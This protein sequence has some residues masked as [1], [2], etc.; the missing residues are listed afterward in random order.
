MAMIVAGGG[1]VSY[2]IQ[3]LASEAV[4]TR[5]AQSLHE[6]LS[7]YQAMW[8]RACGAGMEQ[9]EV[10]GWL[11]VGLSLYEMIRAMEERWSQAAVREGKLAQ[12]GIEAEELRRLYADWLR[13]AELAM[14]KVTELRRQGVELAGRE[15]FQKA[16]A[17]VKLALSTD[18]DA[19]KR[20]EE[21]L[22]SGG[23]LTLEE[24]RDELRRP[25]R[26]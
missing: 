18:V 24:V 7:V 11:R 9:K 25:A 8:D 6:H 2:D 20:A 1:G 10:E 17:Q 3:G 15:D 4:M 5:T 13:P 16:W 26:R 19:V 12:D 21:Q 23:G 22:R 14:T